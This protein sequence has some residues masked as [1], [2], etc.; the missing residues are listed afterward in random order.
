MLLET[1]AGWG[2]FFQLYHAIIRHPLWRL[3]LHFFILLWED[4]LT[5]LVLQDNSSMI[6]LKELDLFGCD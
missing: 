4:S 5:N 1:L 6:E 2:D 3:G